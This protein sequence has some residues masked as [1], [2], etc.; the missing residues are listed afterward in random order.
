MANQNLID[1][2]MKLRDELAGAGN[3][4]TYKKN[5]LI[6]AGAG[7]GKTYTMVNRI[8]NQLDRTRV[9][10]EKI[11]AITFT[12]KATQEM[13]G[14]IVDEL[15]SRYEKAKNDGDAVKIEKLRKLLDNV[16]QMQIST[17]HSFCSKLL[18]TMPF[19]SPLG[20]DFEHIEDDELDVL[21]DSFFYNSISG[22]E[23][24]FQEAIEITGISYTDLKFNFKRLCEESAE[25]QCLDLCDKVIR[26]EIDKAIDNLVKYY[27]IVWARFESEAG[28]HNVKSITSKTVQAIYPQIQKVLNYVEYGQKELFI[29]AFKDSINPFVQYPDIPI[30]AFIRVLPGAIKD[31]TAS[32]KHVIDTTKEL[33]Y[34]L[35]MHPL[36]LLVSSYRIEKCRLGKASSGDLLYYAKEMLL[37]SYE[38][39]EYFHNRYTTIYVDEMQDTD[40]VQAQILFYLA[41]D[42]N[43]FDPND[44]RNCKPTPGSLFL[45]GDP[46]QAIYRFRGADISVYNTLKKLFSGAKVGANS[47]IGTGEKLG[48]VVPLQINFRS[49]QEI[50]DF[51]DVA[52][53]ESLDGGEY[54]ADYSSML[55]KNGA[56]D[57]SVIISY[58]AAGE[59][60]ET[61][62]EEDAKQ[63]AGFIYTMVKDKVIV[64]MNVD[65]KQKEH[66]AEYGDFM[67]LTRSKKATERY[68]EALSQYGIPC[69]MAGEK[70]FSDIAAIKR[71]SYI[72]NFLLDKTDETKLVLAL[73]KC[74]GIPLETINHYKQ[75]CGYMTLDCSS[76]HKA[77]ANSGEDF[78]EF[79]PLFSALYEINT[80][81]EEVLELPAVTVLENILHKSYAVWN[82]QNKDNEADYAMI[83]QYLEKVRGAGTV[84]FYDMAK[85]AL[86]ITG[87][88]AERE[89]LL[90]KEENCVRIMNLHKAKG[91][92]AEVI[93]LAYGVEYNS[94]PKE[95]TLYAG[96]S[97]NLYSCLVRETAFGTSVIGS[98]EN[99]DE[100]S[101]IEKKFL[102]AEQL[103]LLYVAATRPKTAL[104]V[105]ANEKL[106]SRANPPAWKQV[107]DKIEERLVNSAWVNA[108]NV[109]DGVDLPETCGNANVDKVTCS[110]KELETK[111]IDNVKRLAE[112]TTVSVSPSLL[113]KH[114]RSSI[115]SAEE[116]ETEFSTIENQYETSEVMSHPHGADW[117]TII[118]RVFELA[119]KNK[120]YDEV[121]LRKLVYR[122]IVE[123]IDIDDLNVIQKRLLF[124]ECKPSINYLVD[125]ALKQIGFICNEDC[126][127]R[128]LIDNAKKCYTELPFVLYE[129]DMTAELVIKVAKVIDANAD[130]PLSMNGIIDLAVFKD[131]NWIVVDYKTDILLDDESE[132]EY[133][134]RLKEQYTNQLACYDEVLTRMG[135]GK[136]SNI[137]ICAVN[138]GGKLVE[139][140]K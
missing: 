110:A 5:Y 87:S 76:I 109:L 119:V 29:A 61:R 136:V 116:Q 132:E 124:G 103:R 107:A 21:M 39:R 24:I 91:L 1:K 34:N 68:V 62:A 2:E 88:V 82:K 79:K 121:S 43:S 134:G 128:K 106:S 4:D 101:K 84:D 89:L 94:V 15:F 125:E 17:I 22:E 41:G 49:S 66:P 44:W 6:E 122:A 138:L 85:N 100:I 117:G 42:E 20:P 93:I 135:K 28:A 81:K 64:G 129:S 120:K 37:K 98:G 65:E 96:N 26:S 105:N 13:L 3:L 11:A 55:A 75:R 130:K 90:K 25:I 59:D 8:I 133:I 92:E 118:H 31:N 27:D 111:I 127:L 56:S 70:T 57:K 7:A 36:K 18:K 86:N 14:R 16:D 35:C 77:L 95:T 139:I 69:N 51:V 60:K 50:C 137:Y 54:Q 12:E 140:S 48:E 52:F 72:L 73:F 45:V 104:I 58:L 19:Y 99:W 33:F 83:C 113:E 97:A 40:P 102:D 78:T 10:P 80:L 32:F 30:D 53:S 131:N 9:E 71:A 114:M 115:K 63:V 126:D 108:L 38:A 46:K 67:I 23:N 123:T 112:S 74:Y 47:D